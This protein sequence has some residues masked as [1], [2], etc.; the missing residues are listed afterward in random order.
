MHQPQVS[1]SCIRSSGES[2]LR[3]QQ[4][5]PKLGL[6]SSR[7]ACRAAAQLCEWAASCSTALTTA[8]VHS[9]AVQTKAP[10]RYLLHPFPCCASEH[11]TSSSSSSSVPLS[12]L[13]AGADLVM[14]SSH[15]VLS[16]MGQ[17]AMLHVRGPRV[18]QARVSKALQ[19]GG[20]VERIWGTYQASQC[21]CDVEHGC[22]H[23]SCK[24]PRVKQAHD[25]KALQVRYCCVW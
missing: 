6:S 12:A 22:T 17:A 1:S 8:V 21:C 24:G 3:R 11:T 15:K 18:S 4:C 19:V 10:T 5:M 13:A 7:T 2:T 9:H 16:A 20:C 23:A 25:R 14:Q